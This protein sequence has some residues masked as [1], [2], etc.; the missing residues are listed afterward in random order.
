MEIGLTRAG[1]WMMAYLSSLTNDEK[2]HKFT[3][4]RT[5]HLKW[6]LLVQHL[7]VLLRKQ[8][9]HVLALVRHFP[10]QLG[11]SDNREAVSMQFENSR[12]N[13]PGQ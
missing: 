9:L 12:Q 11:R 6:K 2:G 5:F 1:I 10:A 7:R 8:M 13:Q 4:V 3:V